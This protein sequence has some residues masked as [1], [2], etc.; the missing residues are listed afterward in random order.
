MGV[1]AVS[2]NGCIAEKLL[3]WYAQARRDLPWRRTRDPY[4]IWVSEIMLQQT[5]V[6]TVKAY[7]HRFLLRLPDVR[8]LADA[9]EQDVLKLWEG[10][11]YYS[12]A[13][14]MQR[15]ARMI[16]SQCDG[17]F[18]PSYEALLTLPGIGAYTAGAVASIAF[19][20]PTP[21]VDGNVKRVAARVFGIRAPI[22][23]KPAQA[24][25]AQTLTAIL[26]TCDAGQFNQAL[27]E[28]GATLCAPRAPQCDACPLCSLCDASREGDAESLPMQAAKQPP[29][30]L[31]MGVCILTWD[32]RTLL[33]RRQERL[34]HGLYVFW[35]AEGDTDA[36]GLKGL[37]QEEGLRATHRA[38][39]GE[40]THVF[41]HRIWRMTLH[42][43]LLDAP[44]S[45]AWLAAHDAVLADARDIRA[46]PLPTAMKAARQEALAL[47]E[48]GLV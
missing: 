5:R 11:G 14:N 31:D 23:S 30:T 42:H 15:A 27:M 36:Y 48:N 35:L 40:A 3:G 38:A 8:A 2:D 10:L 29:K 4:C 22:D 24:M 37:L 19:G 28:L 45:A 7:Y 1:R 43:F 21:A 6:E 17:V 41:T 25:V 33:L 34:L 39:L 26:Q 32:G 44:P 47:L 12:R 16:V 18:P 13:R 9:P 46:L 20:L